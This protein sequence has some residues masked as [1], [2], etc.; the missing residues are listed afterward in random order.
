MGVP[1]D[2]PLV[3]LP[4]AAGRPPDGP[5]ARHET[6][7]PEEAPAAV[8]D[9]VAARAQPG[10]APLAA[11]CA[12][13]PALLEA[14]ARLGEAQLA[15]GDAVG[16]YASAR[17]AYHRGLDRLRK[18][19]WGGTGAVRWAQPANRGFLRGVHLLLAAAAR[20]GEID[21][22]E[23]CRSFLLELDPDDA[24]G[25]AAYPQPPGSDFDPPPLPDG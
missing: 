17:V 13:H 4:L 24:I 16:A 22:S 6:V 9:L 5:P 12:R 21:E 14:W 25:V 8:A 18:H 23:R 19:G 10:L 1:P 11:C 7:L 3:Q 20:L 2:R 15:G